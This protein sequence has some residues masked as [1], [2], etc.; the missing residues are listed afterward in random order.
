MGRSLRCPLTTISK[1][2]VLQSHV[3]LRL[4]ANTCSEDVGESTALLGESIDDRGPGR[5][6]WCLQHVAEDAENTVETLIIL[7]A[8]FSAASLPLNASHHLSQNHQVDDQGR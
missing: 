6:Q 3:R 8:C 5:S 1:Q 2:L 7:V 4:K